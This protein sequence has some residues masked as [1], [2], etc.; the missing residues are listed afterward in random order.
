M[1]DWRILDSNQREHGPFTVEQIREGLREG[2]I[3]REAQFWRDGMT[4]WATLPAVAKELGVVV[5]GSGVVAKKGMSG[6]LIAAIVV[7]VGV[8]VIGGI[9]AAIAVAQ[10][11]DYVARSQ[12]YEGAALAD[13]V[14]TAVAEAYHNNGSMPADNA[15][16]GLAAPGEIVGQY[17]D[18][19]AVDAGRIVVTYSSQPP[20]KAHQAIDGA[21]LVFTPTVTVATDESSIEWACSSDTLP[22]KFCPTSCACQ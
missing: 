10:Y 13:G 11:Q 14:K 8:L 17:V 7:G 3:E 20:R 2:T 6:C 15:A 1:A 12:V 16:A 9:I 18:S 22:Q 21:S 5:S 4:A 19:V